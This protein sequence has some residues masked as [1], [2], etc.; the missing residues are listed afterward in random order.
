MW[1][2]SSTVDEF[3]QPMINCGIIVL[4]PEGMVPLPY[5]N[6]RSM[7]NTTQHMKFAHYVIHLESLA[8]ILD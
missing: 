1:V 7:V 3:L 2:S 6:I 4:V 5:W 8:A